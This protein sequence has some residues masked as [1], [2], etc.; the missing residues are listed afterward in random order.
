MIEIE[1]Q[2]QHLR[3]FPQKAAYWVECSTLI[4]A[5][6]H[7]GKAAAFRAHAI[8]LAPG[9]QATLEDDL[10][11]LSGL[12][13]ETGAQRL[14][15]LGDLLHARAGLDG[16]TLETVQAWRDSCA[17]LEILLVR[18]NHDQRAGDPPDEWRMTV[19]D[20]PFVDPPF[21]YLHTPARVEG[22]Y[23]LGGH[24]H[25]AAH[26]SGR[27]G[28]SLTLPCFWFGARCGVLP[29]FGSFTGTAVV[30]PAQGDQVFVVAEGKVIKIESGERRTKR[31]R[32]ENRE[33]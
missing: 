19:V 9:T 21:A 30:H 32:T 24:I 12:L 2:A 8:P 6:P 28:Q 23:A 27:G 3:L 1:L 29:A 18:G 7:W 15:L 33:P 4:L 20:E 16:H 31:T 13:A 11:R 25:P 10:R 22:G 17:A 26:L 14:V 5:D